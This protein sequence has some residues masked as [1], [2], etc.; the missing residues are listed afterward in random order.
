MPTASIALAPTA[1]PRWHQL[2]QASERP[3]GRTGRSAEI[4][5]HCGSFS[6]A[7]AELHHVAPAPRPRLASG[8]V[9]VS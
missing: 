8:S 6:Q 1:T 4:G 2:G 3:P 9:A 5:T 7:A